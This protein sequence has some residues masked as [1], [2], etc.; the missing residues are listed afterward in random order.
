MKRDEDICHLND[1]AV[2]DGEKIAERRNT[3]LLY[4]ESANV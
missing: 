3:A 4:Q 2:H 1:F